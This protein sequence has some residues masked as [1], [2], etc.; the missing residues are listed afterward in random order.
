MTMTQADWAALKAAQDAGG[1]AYLEQLNQEKQQALSGLPPGAAPGATGATGSGSSSTAYSIGQDAINQV[2]NMYPN[3]AWM[4]DIPS[5]GPLLVQW[6][7]QGVDPNTAVSMLQS[8][9]WYQ[10][11]SDA[12]RKW[13][14][15][16]E[17]D[18]AQAQSDIQAQESSIYATIAAMGV[19]ALPQQI[20]FLAQ[21]SLALGWTDQE[22]KDHIAQGIQ[23]DAQGQPHL[24]SGGMTAGAP[25]NGGVGTIQSTIASLRSEAAKY[26]VPV[27]DTTLQTFATSIANGTMDATSVDAYLATQASSLYPSIAGAIK[28]GITP[29]DY[30][31]PYKEVAAQLLG[32]SPNSID[33]TQAKWNRALSQPG[34][35][36]K[37]QAISLYGWQQLLMQ[38]PQYQYMGSVNAKDRASSIAQGLGEMFG[39][40]ASGPAGSTAFSAAG[41]PRIAGVPIT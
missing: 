19:G 11:N 13:I 12:V 5:V 25:T 18:P 22:I 14:S 38:D 4:L 20:Q 32:V 34:P 30:V 9:S 8:T 26:L 23:Y 39:K 15:E 40:V 7:Q 27:S 6:A 2:Q 28:S 31:T 24:V 3:L 21:Q 37:P 29:A 33:M 16:V 35:D 36:G 41:A 10:T 1:S 17:T